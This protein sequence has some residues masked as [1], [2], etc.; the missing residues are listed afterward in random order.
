MP[1][2]SPV[3]TKHLIKLLKREGFKCIRIKGSHHYF[4]NEIDGRT[5]VVPVHGNRDIG[6][7]LLSSI[8]DD[9]DWSVKEFAKKMKR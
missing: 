5:T 7:V 4:I 8:L 2:L 6:V 3:S 9:L 1:H